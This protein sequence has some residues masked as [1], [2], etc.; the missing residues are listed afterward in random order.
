MREVA[1]RPN[2]NRTSPSTHRQKL[3]TRG[4]KMGLDREI[5]VGRL[6]PQPIAQGT[7]ILGE[8]CSPG[9]ASHVL[10]DRV[11]ED[12]VEVLPPDSRRRVASITDEALDT[13]DFTWLRLVEENQTIGLDAS[14]Q[15]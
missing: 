15:P 9:V 3:E 13:R 1:N 7:C 11:R 10:D 4:N 14:C 5:A 6:N 12:K 8:R 2:Y